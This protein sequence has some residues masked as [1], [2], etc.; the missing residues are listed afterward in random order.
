MSN[1]GRA[2]HYS[3]PED[4]MFAKIISDLAERL[5]KAEAVN[6]SSSQVNPYELRQLDPIRNPEDAEEEDR[7]E[8]ARQWEE[9]WEE[10]KSLRG[11]VIIDSD[12][13]R[14]TE[15]PLHISSHSLREHLTRFCSELKS[16]TW[17]SPTKRFDSELSATLYMGAEMMV[18]S[19]SI[20]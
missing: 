9:I 6:S 17:W 5:K 2:K 20:L 18:T 19:I 8:M 3:T 1:D 13:E 7:V 16:Q 10:L 14:I 11:F 15:S 4:W 12:F